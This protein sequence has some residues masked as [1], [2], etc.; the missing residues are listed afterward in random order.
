MCSTKSKKNNHLKFFFLSTCP[1]EQS[2]HVLDKHIFVAGGEVLCVKNKF[3][4]ISRWS[5]VTCNVNMQTELTE[6]HTKVS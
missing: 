5:A 3:S 1:S 6:F 4:F 2:R